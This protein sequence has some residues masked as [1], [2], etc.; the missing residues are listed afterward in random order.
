MIIKR[1]SNKNKF[2]VEKD[3]D[4][5]SFAYWNSQRQNH[6]LI[7]SSRTKNVLFRYISV[8]HVLFSILNFKTSKQRGKKC[9]QYKNINLKFKLS[10]WKI[11]KRTAATLQVFLTMWWCI[12][13][14]LK[15]SFKTHIWIWWD[16]R[17]GYREGHF[18]LAKQ[19]LIIKQNPCQKPHPT[20]A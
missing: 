8:G 4:S 9:K 19:I 6:N 15:K 1:F 20:L 3:L 16:N 5:E 2:N 13:W 11:E 10:N 12:K 18:W 17:M 7:P 14:N